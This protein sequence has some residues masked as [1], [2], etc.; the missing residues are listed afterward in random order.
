MLS[1][2]ELK[3]SIDWV[4]KSWDIEQLDTNAGKIQP[5]LVF[6]SFKMFLTAL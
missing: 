6:H 4:L 1:V 3:K 2:G 5:Q